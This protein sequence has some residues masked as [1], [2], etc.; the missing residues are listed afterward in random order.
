MKAVLMDP[1]ALEVSCFQDLVV[2]L[3]VPGLDVVVAV[4]FAVRQIVPLARSPS[5]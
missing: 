3:L 2:N 5:G 4:D 1:D